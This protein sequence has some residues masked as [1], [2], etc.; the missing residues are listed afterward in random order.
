MYNSIAAWHCSARAE[1][2]GRKET[3][4]ARNSSALHVLNYKD[5]IYISRI[6]VHSRHHHP[7]PCHFLHLRGSSM[8]SDTFSSSGRAKWKERDE[9][10]NF[11]ISFICMTSFMESLSLP[12][13]RVKYIC[14]QEPNL[15]TDY[16]RV[17][18]AGE[19]AREQRQG[20]IVWLK[21][22][23][24]I[25]LF[26]WTFSK[27][28]KEY[29]HSFAFFSRVQFSMCTEAKIALSTICRV[30][31]L[32]LRFLFGLSLRHWVVKKNVA[33][34]QFLFVFLVLVAK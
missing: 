31:N 6:F 13:C 28:A 16:K 30:F 15:T 19:R 23:T 32:F 5:A 33:I 26:L 27:M 25:S 34:W 8:N 3:S 24:A 12:L 11:E 9:K 21:L 4:A 1:S 7:M 2:E 29:A 20:S 10:K 18:R 17:F 14:M 22:A